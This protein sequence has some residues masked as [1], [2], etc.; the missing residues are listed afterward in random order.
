[1][2]RCRECGRRETHDRAERLDDLGVAPR[3][4]IADHGFRHFGERRGIDGLALGIACSDHPPQRLVIA[5]IDDFRSTARQNQFLVALLLQIEEM[6]LVGVADGGKDRHVGPDDALQ[7]LHFARLGDAGLEDGQLLVALQHQHRE[8]HAQLG[9]VA[10]GRAVELH[11]CGQFFGDPLLDDG[12]AVRPR[13]ADHRAAELRPMIGRQRLQGPDGILDDRIPAAGQRLD[14]MLD[15]KSPGA[16]IVHLTD[17][18][19]R[20]VIGTAQGHE[21]GTLPHFA[22]ER[23]AVCDHRPHADVAALELAAADGGDLR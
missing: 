6:F 2:G 18:V 22:R 16:A 13:D 11:A 10:L 3:R 8:R 14:G 12:L 21:H 15:Q 23:A 17:E 1:M 19:V 20:V 9:V 5:M 4:S 7:P